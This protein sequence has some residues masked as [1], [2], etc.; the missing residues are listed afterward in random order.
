[1]RRRHREAAREALAA[2]GLQDLA[3]RPIGAL[4]GGQ[5]QRVF[6]ARA[7]AQDA[8]LVILDEPFAGVDAVSEEILWARLRALR[9]E[10]RTVVVV[11]HDLDTIGRAFDDVVLLNRRLVAAGPVAKR[12]PARPCGRLWR[13]PRRGAGRVT[14]PR[15]GRTCPPRG[16]EPAPGPRARMTDLLAA[17]A[18]QGGYNTTVVIVGASLLGASAGAVGVFAMLRRRALVADAAAHAMLPGVALGFLANVAIGWPGRSLA[19]VLAGALAAAALAVA[20]IAAIER[21]T[22]LKADTAIGSVLG[23]AF[24][25][26]VVLVSIVQ[27]LPV[28]GQAGLDAFILG[29]TS[30]LRREDA[31][32][33]GAMALL[34]FAVLAATWKELR[35]LA[36]D[37]VFARTIGMR[38]ERIDLLLAALILLVVALG[39]RTVG[40]VL[41]VAVLVIPPA[42]A[43]F[44]SDRLAVVVVASAGIGAAGAWVG[45]ALSSA[46]PGLPTGS[47]IV[48]AL[49]AI[50]VA[51]AAFGAARRRARSAAAPRETQPT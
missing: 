23:V 33:L 37:P 47:T 48:L 28:G 12:S 27:G 15:S 1:V 29:S 16:R 9:D 14:P 40:A 51:S 36:F 17:L 18:L 7:L 13:P 19:L 49:A 34:L 10:G 5:Q 46:H 38:P 30:G 42:A 43:R 44:W 50:F 20:A 2:V 26:G 4:S 8:D 25:L 35:L 3:R 41:A 31:L 24:G 11:H 32:L 39:L 45:A 22:R 6:L 21:R